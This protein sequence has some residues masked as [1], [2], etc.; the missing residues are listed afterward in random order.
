M[1]SFG[2][3]KVRFI[4]LNHTL[5]IGESYM[6]FAAS[7]LPSNRTFGFFFTFVFLLTGG[8]FYIENSRSMAYILLTGAV[9]FFLVT[10]LKPVILLPFNRLWMRFGLLL[11]LIVSPFVLGLIFFG[12]F[13]PSAFLMRLAGRDELQ[14]QCRVKSTYWIKRET[15]TPANSF[16]KQF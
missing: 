6:K 9:V 11:S 13:T 5:K 15:P 16:L 12:M 3:N 7:E 2:R 8:Y 14:L 1:K 10:L 4:D